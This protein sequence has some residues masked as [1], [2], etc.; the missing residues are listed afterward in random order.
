MAKIFID[1]ELCKSCGLCIYICPR[2]VFEMTHH[3]NKKGYNY[4]TAVNEANCIACRQCEN[5]CPD[6]VIH[7]EKQE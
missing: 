5:G 3:V 1:K 6:F 4:V 7:V 2:G